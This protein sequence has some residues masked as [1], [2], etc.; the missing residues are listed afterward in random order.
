MLIFSVQ[1]ASPP[2]WHG[3]R[4][5]S[6]SP[7]YPPPSPVSDPSCSL[8]CQEVYKHFTSNRFSSPSINKLTSVTG[9]MTMYGNTTYTSSNQASR[10]ASVA[11]QT[12]HNNS[13]S[14]QHNLYT[15]NSKSQP[16]RKRSETGESRFRLRPEQV[17]YTVDVRSSSRE[18]REAKWSEEED[19]M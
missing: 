3:K 16:S 9:L 10:G 6:P 11:L 14:Q 17:E 5:Y 13:H 19:R 12:L 4:P 15:S 18:D 2:R 8:L 7:S 1:S